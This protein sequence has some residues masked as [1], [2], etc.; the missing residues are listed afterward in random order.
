[1]SGGALGGKILGGGG[2]G[3]RLLKSISVP[4][5]SLALV[6]GIVVG[7]GEL[8]D[9]GVDPTVLTGETEEPESGEGD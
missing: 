7:T 3:G 6:S 4:L 2:G 9:K 5:P 1:M 8:P